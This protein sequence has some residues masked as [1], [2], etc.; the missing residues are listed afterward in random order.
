[1]TNLNINWYPGHM[2]KTMDNIKS[3][4]KLVDVVLE[5]VDARIPIA[6]RNPLLDEVLGDKP[7]VVLLNKMDLANESMN[8]KWLEYFKAK[9]YEAILIDSVKGTNLNKIESTSRQLLTEKFKKLEEKN[10]N[11][12]RVRAMIVG[13]P[14]VGKST[15]INR[16]ANRRSA[17]VGNRPGVTRQNQWIKTGKDFELLDTPGVLWP[18][19]ESEEIGLDLAFTGAIKDEIMDTETLAFKLIEKLNHIDK[20]II[21]TRYKIETEGLSTLET[22]EA[23]GQKRGCLIRGG[24]FDYEKISNIVLDEFRK[25][26]LG[27]ITLEGPDDYNG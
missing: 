19:F 1:M 18:K 17:K 13:V 26:V 20:G 16:I 14:N 24:E 5:I 11:L 12:K 8:K 23:I 6:S 21:E 22:M 7:R 4:L 25:G 2:K 15:L 3:S 27:R 9:G 10:L